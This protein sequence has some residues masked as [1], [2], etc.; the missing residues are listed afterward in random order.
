M[1]LKDSQGNWINRNGRP[2]PEANVDPIAKRRDDAVSR[3][4]TK[5][6]KL[7]AEMRKVKEE[8]LAEVM[9]YIGHLQQANSIKKQATKGNYTL[10]DYANLQQVQVSMNNIIEF[11]ERLNLAKTLIDKCLIKWTKRGNQNVR[12]I[13]N[14]AFDVDKKGNVNKMRIFGLM[15]LQIND[16]DWKQAMELIRASM[17]VSDTRQYLNIR[18]RKNNFDKWDFINL[19]FSSL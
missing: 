13:I 9:A 2:I 4:V 6:L 11:D 1:P 10:S 14:D 5:A 3:M 17:Q 19:N 16:K 12:A 8:I 15:A 7:E 18:T